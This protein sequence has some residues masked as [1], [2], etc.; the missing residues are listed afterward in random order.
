MLG[1]SLATENMAVNKTRMTPVFLELTVY[2]SM[3]Y[4]TQGNACLQLQENGWRMVVY[5][6]DLKVDFINWHLAPEAGD[7]ACST[8]D[9]LTCLTMNRTNY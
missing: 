2:L 7:S 9:L 1:I 6:W 5:L 8:W 4:A 3:I